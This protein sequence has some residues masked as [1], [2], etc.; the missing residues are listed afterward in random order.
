MKE[1]YG[2]GERR[3]FFFFWGGREREKAFKTNR[4]AGRG[5]ERKRERK[6]DIYYILNLILFTT[7]QKLKLSR[8]PFYLE[9][10]NKKNEI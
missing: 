7:L 6:S 5:K 4:V 9:V 8:R 2:E 1:I 10:N 3:I